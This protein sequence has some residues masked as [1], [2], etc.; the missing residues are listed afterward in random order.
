MRRS[1][2]SRTRVLERLAAAAAL[3]TVMLC[4]IAALPAWAQAA[5]QPLGEMTDGA[6]PLE[7]ATRVR[8]HGIAG[9]LSIRP[10][11]GGEL[12]FLSTLLAKPAEKSAVVLRREPGL[13]EVVPPPDSQVARLLEVSVPGGVAL[14]IS[15]SSSRIEVRGLQG[16]LRVEGEALDVALDAIGSATVVLRNSKARVAGT[17][18][19]LTLD[20]VASSF[21]VE[22]VQGALFATQTGGTLL[23]RGL[24]GDGE[25]D[26]GDV[27]L[28]L[29]GSRAG[30]RVRAHGGTI[31]LEE[32]GQGAHLELTD[33]PL[34][35][36]SCRGEIDVSTDSGVRFE[37]LEADLHVDGYGASVT[38]T[39]NGQLVEIVTDGAEIDLREIQGPVRIQ[40]A[41][42]SLNL[43]GIGGELI[44]LA[45]SSTISIARTAAPVTVQNDYGD[46]AVR[47][48]LGGV[49]IVS[50]DG[51][52]HLTEISGPVEVESNG[53]QVVVS[54]TTLDDKNDSYILNEG[55]DVDVVFP[56]RARCRV[57]ATSR[58]G[59]VSSEIPDAPSDPDGSRASGS[60]NQ[61]ESPTVR[62]ESQGS[63]H[64]AMTQPPRR[65]GRVP[66][67]L[68]PREPSGGEN[69]R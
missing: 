11:R 56:W 59:R 43:E 60:L 34:E 50:S 18:G 67:D 69:P 8:I 48:A 64:L 13:L 5:A 55:G 33:A 36:T 32:L 2:A 7:D 68:P 25:L 19:A 39:G 61:G 24:V 27:A 51:D 26:L 49:R 54:W 65:E 46:I 14:E 35:L 47:A 17:G 16:G 28:T 21:E 45:T 22:G 37:N 41:N 29:R 20:G 58:H 44:V 66:R 23:V 12:R 3:T 38:G 30:L 10:G 62:I 52:V 42:L 57:D 6:V 63:I 9:R 15:S 53:T 40:G 31:D 1:G 4:P